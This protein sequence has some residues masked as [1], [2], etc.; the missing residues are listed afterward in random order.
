M[1]GLF[2]AAFVFRF[3]PALRL[4]FDAA[5]LFANWLRD[6]IRNMLVESTERMPE[7]VRNAR[8]DHKAGE[9]HPNPRIFAAI[10]G[11]SLPDR[12]KADFRLAGE[13]FSLV[14]AGTET[15]AVSCIFREHR[16][17]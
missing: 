7:R 1:N 9:A 3:F 16:I 12:E 2:K 17:R 15:T 10:M 13:G 4:L 11:S 14:T 6:D 8:Q 5:P